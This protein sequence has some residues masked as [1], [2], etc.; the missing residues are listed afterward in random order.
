[1]S[2]L[3][4]ASASTIAAD[5]RGAIRA[6]PSLAAVTRRL[7]DYSPT[8]MVSLLE[9]SGPL[10]N[11]EDSSLELIVSVRSKQ[12]GG[13]AAEALNELIGRQLSRGDRARGVAL[14]EEVYEGLHW[15]DLLSL[16]E[17]LAQ[18]IAAVG[19]D[20]DEARTFDATFVAQ[21][22]ASAIRSQMGQ[23][24]PE[25]IASMSRLRSWL[26]T[27]SVEVNA[28]LDDL[29]QQI[30]D[31]WSE[32]ETFRTATEQVSNQLEPRLRDRWKGRR[33][34]VVGGRRPLWFG[35]LA[36][37]IALDD[38]SDW[39]SSEPGKRPS[40]DQLGR[41]IAG[42]KLDAL[43]ILVDYIAHAT[44]EIRDEAKER[45]IQVVDARSGRYSFVKALD[46]VK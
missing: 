37:S 21:Y 13:R 10:E 14:L 46:G 5:N 1:M 16:A 28:V 43:V 39:I 11:L 25:A 18:A 44:S 41:K 42:G 15:Y 22:A 4:T 34:L 9:A 2:V 8:E 30:D 24:L 35:E 6:G 29:S 19:T 3:D 20:W 27:G 33:L 23:D 36:K 31:A 45:S 17:R 12:G 38:K 7:G 40:R 26:G 32:N